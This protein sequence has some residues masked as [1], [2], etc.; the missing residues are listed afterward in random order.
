MRIEK[1]VKIEREDGGPLHVQVFEVRPR[2]LLNLL[3]DNDVDASI[4]ATIEKMLP[5][6]SDIELEE[7]VGLYP[8]EQEILIDAFKEVNRPFLS[9]TDQLG[10]GPILEEVRRSL[11]SDWQRIATDLLPQD[12]LAASTMAGVGSSAP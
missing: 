8:S 1:K 9:M 12:T 4:V 7:F 6:C 5:L 11:V 3:P 2:D 10:L